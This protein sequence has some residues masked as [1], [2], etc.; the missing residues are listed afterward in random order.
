M[1]FLSRHKSRPSPQ[2]A[3]FD[4]RSGLTTPPRDR[5]EKSHSLHSGGS[6]SIRKRLSSFTLLGT[7][8][9][10]NASRNIS[11][12]SGGVGYVMSNT[13]HA[14]PRSR[15]PSPEPSLEIRPPS[16]LG[17]IRR[18][19]E[20]EQESGEVL[21]ISFKSWRPHRQPSVSAPDLSLPLFRWE[22]A[23]AEGKVSSELGYLNRDQTPEPPRTPGPIPFD[24]SRIPQELLKSLFADARKRDLARLARVSRA[25]VWPARSALYEHL[26]LKD[27]KDPRRIEQCM[28]LLASK[29]EVA[30]ILRSFICHL[31]PELGSADGAFTPS[32]TVTFAIAFTNMI[33]VQ[34]LTIPRFTPHIFLHSTFQLKRLSFVCE[35]MLPNE[36]RDM[37]TWLKTQPTLTSLRFP[38]LVMESTL[39]FTRPNTNPSHEHKLPPSSSRG[40]PAPLSIPSH[41]LSKLSHFHGPASFIPIVVPDRPV[42]SLAIT[43][44]TTLY[45][46]LRPS[47]LMASVKR[48]KALVTSLSV[49]ASGQKK[50]DARTFERVLM[51]VGSELGESLS[52]LEIEWILE[53]EVSLAVSSLYERSLL[54]YHLKS[55]STSKSSQSYLDLPLSILF[56]CTAVYHHLPPALLP[57]PFP[58]RPPH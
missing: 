16:G 43:I 24:F 8:K 27:V 17:R 51:S 18:A 26:N 28:A 35:S 37:F 9:R 11:P 5:E 15:S 53:D 54:I 20:T 10:P 6:S 55:F 19:S 42:Q 1:S 49:V 7:S 58:S 45:D 38:N 30:A 57:H 52:T 40:S 44:H 36:C 32:A 50:V 4:K 46:G 13:S 22:E 14:R 41:A 23:S 25:F 29:R 3:H 56:A 39:L 47:A 21:D 48:S 34:S 31:A 33:H 2:T 12:S